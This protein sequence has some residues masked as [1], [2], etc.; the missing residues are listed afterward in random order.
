M[1]SQEQ[2]R[3]MEQNGAYLPVQSMNSHAQISPDTHFL[4]FFI[5]L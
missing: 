5:I 1:G 3:A 2:P 4:T